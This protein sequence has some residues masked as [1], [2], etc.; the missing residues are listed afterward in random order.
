MLRLQHHEGRQILVHAAQPIAQPRPDAGPPRDHES[1]LE[2][3]HGGLVIDGVGMHGADDRDIVHH[4]R[5]VGQQFRNPRAR[6]A[7]LR[8]LED[9]RSDGK[10]RLAARHGGEALALANRIGQVLIEHLLHLRLVVEGLH[11]RRR[12]DQMQIDAALRLGREM[13]EARQS[14]S[15][16][17]AVALPV[18]EASARRRFPAPRAQNWRRFPP[19]ME[20]YASGC[21]LAGSFVQHLVEIHHL[22]GQHGHGRVVGGRQRRIGLALALIQ[23]LLR[24]VFVRRVVSR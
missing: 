1:G 23:E 7:V 20:G 5:R 13:R 22:A 3:R 11:L 6:L 24:F 4:L 9:G 10:P 14:G 8:E 19:A 18:S 2:K 15:V 16:R 17:C 12:A 21:W